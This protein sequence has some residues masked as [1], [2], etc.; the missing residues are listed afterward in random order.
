[1]RTARGV[2]VLLSSLQVL[3]I[4][5]QAIGLDGKHCYPL[6]QLTGP[7][8]SSEN[9]TFPSQKYAAD[10]SFK[11][12]KCSTEK[13]ENQINLSAGV[14]EKKQAGPLAS[15]GLISGPLRC[16]ERTLLELYCISLQPCCKY[17]SC[18]TL[19]NPRNETAKHNERN[20]LLIQI[21]FCFELY[22]LFFSKKNYKEQSSE[23]F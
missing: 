3:G 20:L 4:R 23:V 10:Q 7:I 17:I 15:A 18:L 9:K 2:A 6:S 5:T 1:M 11:L 19:P 22:I 8:N 16:Q 14:G 13:G 12:L 21:I